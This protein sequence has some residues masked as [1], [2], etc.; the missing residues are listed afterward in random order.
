MF[1]LTKK[2]HDKLL[3][4]H[5]Q[6]FSVQRVNMSQLAIIESREL[7]SSLNVMSFSGN[8]IGLV[9]LLFLASWSFLYQINGQTSTDFHGNSH[10]SIEQRKSNEIPDRHCPKM[11][12]DDENNG[13]ENG[14]KEACKSRHAFTGNLGFVSD[15]R[16]RGISQTLRRPA[17]QGGLDYAHASGLYLGTWASN[18]DGTTHYYNN[19]SM[20]WDFYGGLK[21]NLFPCSIP[22]LTCNVGLIYYYYPGGKAH[23]KQNV[24]YD[25]AEWYLELTYKWLS[26]KFSQSLTNYFGINSN[27]PPFNWKRNHIAHKNG[28][29]RYSGYIEA[30]AIFEIY[31]KLC[32]HFLKGGKLN[33]L[34]HIGHVHVRNYNELSYTEW[35]AA[36]TQEFD[37]FNILLTYVGTNA[38]HPYYDVPD[39]GFHSRKHELGAQGIVLSVIKNF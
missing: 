15:Y 7:S 2:E 25:T 6:F 30:N 39:N 17:I 37:W 38:Q 1:Y 35:R 22:E 16:F 8:R 29:S 32:W 28:N 10:C 31:E 14:K 23:V 36:L 18:V 24:R 21:G 3:D 12:S 26:I 5:L 34:L 13:K 9:S 33:L 20:E 4:K 11:D 27:D 19:T